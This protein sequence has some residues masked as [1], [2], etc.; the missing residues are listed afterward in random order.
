MHS[1]FQEI[2]RTRGQKRQSGE[3][4]PTNYEFKIVAKNG[5]VRWVLL[6]GGS[7]MF[8]GQPSGLITVQDITGMKEAFQAVQGSQHRLQE[9]LDMLPIAVYETDAEFRVIMA[10]PAGRRMFA[11]GDDFA[12]T[13]L[14]VAGLITGQQRDMAA[15]GLQEFA[16]HPRYLY[17]EFMA[18]ALDGREFP[19]ES[20]ELPV[21][22]PHGELAGIR[23]III[24]LSEKKL[25]EAEQIKINKL[26]S[27][28]ILAGGIAHDF[29]NFLGAIL[30]NISLMRMH[31]DADGEIQELA[32]E[33]EKACERARN[34]TRQLLTFSRGGA[35]VKAQGHL[36]TIVRVQSI[37]FCAVR[38]VHGEFDFAPVWADQCR[39]RQISQVTRIW[40]SMPA[41]RC[42][43]AARCT[44]RPVMPKLMST[45]CLR[46][47]LDAMCV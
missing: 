19:A 15:A 11:L 2:V 13:P 28:G 21:T 16:R 3:N 7:V 39:Q 6:S 22:G 30:G 10:N 26:E 46:W 43:A 47:P 33:A 18:C 14:S 34:L 4:A 9:T 20:H 29:N 25:F 23:G 1:D 32:S 37:L 24:D 12:E 35:P 5:D 36:D 17:G 41:R 44:F 45:M 31:C 38:T 27:L 42:P 8:H 40:R